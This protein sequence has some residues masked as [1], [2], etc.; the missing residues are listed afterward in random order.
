MFLKE[1]TYT[2]REKELTNITEDIGVS[3]NGSDKSD[4]E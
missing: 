4:E 3:A 1:C 2:V